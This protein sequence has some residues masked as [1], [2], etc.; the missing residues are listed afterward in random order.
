LAYLASV[1]LF[2]VLVHRLTGD[3]WV[4]VLGAAVIVPAPLT[5]DLAVRAKQYTLDQ[6][7]T[8]GVAARH[9][10]TVQSDHAVASVLVR[11]GAVGGRRS[12]LRVGLPEQRGGPDRVRV[13]LVVRARED[14]RQAE[15]R[16]VGGAFS[17]P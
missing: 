5:V 10:G 14:R 1:A 9:G 16:P 8:V 13:G 3:P 4:T 12:L 2:A 6:L 15:R 7:V 11:T 17:W